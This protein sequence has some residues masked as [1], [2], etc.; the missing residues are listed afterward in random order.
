MKKRNIL[1]LTAAILQ[2]AALT[3]ALRPDN[4]EE[5]IFA[6]GERTRI[7][8]T[9]N[10]DNTVKSGICAIYGYTGEPVGEAMLTETGKGH[11]ILNLPEQ[12]AG[13]RG[14]Y[15]IAVP[16][17]S[18][19]RI[20]I[21]VLP[22]VRTEEADEFF[23]M[24]TCFSGFR[25]FDNI[26]P[27]ENFMR[28]LHKCGIK[29]V[30]E[31]LRWHSI[32]GTQERKYEFDPEPERFLSKRKLESQY[33]LKVLE[34]CHLPA[35]WMPGSDRILYPQ[36]LIKTAES[37]RDMGK[38]YAPYW[39]SFEVWN[40][41]DSVCFGQNLPGCIYGGLLRTM[42]GEFRHAGIPAKIISGVF[43]P[44]IFSQKALR[45]AEPDESD[46]AYT[47]RAIRQYLE[48]GLLD[49]A[50]EMSFH[51]YDEVG[52]VTRC[53]ALLRKIMTDYPRG[54]LP[55]R[56]TE[57]GCKWDGHRGLRAS[58]EDDL[59]SA[60]QITGKAAEAKAVGIR[61]FYTFV[62][63]SYTEDNVGGALDNYGMFDGNFT[64]MRSF[65]A[66]AAAAGILAGKRYI[67]DLTGIEGADAVW[68]FRK[69]DHSMVTAVIHDREQNG[70]RIPEQYAEG[71]LTG[72]DGRQLQPGADGMCLEKDGIYYLELPLEKAEING[73][74]EQMR[75]LKIADSWAGEP[76]EALPLVIQ[77]RAKDFWSYDGFPFRGGDTVENFEIIFN[78]L[79]E[80]AVETHP[81]FRL[82]AG[83]FF[84]E[85]P[86]EKLNIGPM[87][88]ASV[89][90][91]LHF[92]REKLRKS[93]DRNITVTVVEEKTA[94]PLRIRLNPEQWRD[95]AAAEYG[96]VQA[97]GPAV[98]YTGI[99]AENWVP[100]NETSDRPDIS[101]ELAFR[102]D[103]RHL[104]LLVRVED[105]N[106][107]HQTAPVNDMWNGDSV[108]LA[109]QTDGG[110]FY[111][112]IAGGET[113]GR[114]AVFTVFSEKGRHLPVL[115]E[116]EKSHLELIRTDEQHYTYNLVA[117]LD[118][119]GGKKLEPGTE[120][121]ASVLINSG[122]GKSR[123]GY[124]QWGSG[125][126]GQKNPGEYNRVI[127]K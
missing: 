37:W 76:R 106:G 88:A 33:G 35:W 43:C 115:A 25:L 111:S 89:N 29:S 117:D 56:I 22:E 48:N 10:D 72:A 57:S 103:E 114:T 124:L 30:R 97:N 122:D 75:L 54:N 2:T 91:K 118:E 82:P 94:S 107:Y 101:A 20:G 84:A 73:D 121:S 113:A 68:C 28:I 55:L 14:F 26:G 45:G 100:L 85:P 49:C 23:G 119:L 96:I 60:R 32:Q 36:D 116:T 127:L 9:A 52:T 123:N 92:D 53:T 78:N 39:E 5:L 112:E 12:L 34:V 17:D 83:T 67:G 104:Q 51:V 63:N 58:V 24:D 87:T 11:C 66:Y 86:P 71:K 64:P 18:G 93:A 98:K 102:Y 27:A 50:D 74:T 125:I 126:G 38:A 70:F 99:S 1:C 16:G 6:P 79:T 42:S 62:L 8:F 31:R 61:R 7:G 105:K 3:A 109:L 19:Q 40:E 15:E 69:P 44:G 95:T 4:P 65:A 120:I 13:K 46:T 110:A 81:D 90:L 77:C 41:P 80:S 47:G 21:L 59:N 108:Q